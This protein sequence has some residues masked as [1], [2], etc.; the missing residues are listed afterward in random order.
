MEGD[1]SFC[2]SDAEKIQYRLWSK[3][4]IVPGRRCRL[5]AKK[6]VT[7]VTLPDDMCFPKQAF[8]ARLTLDH[9]RGCIFVAA[10][11]L[12][13]YSLCFQV[14]LEVLSGLPHGFLSLNSFSRE[15]QSA[16]DYILERIRD[17]V[18]A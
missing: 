12:I 8:S 11:A 10:N 5:G 9:T 13:L 3:L 1:K 4:A 18:L 2:T 7:R 15:C 16:V 6:N 14:R 17:V